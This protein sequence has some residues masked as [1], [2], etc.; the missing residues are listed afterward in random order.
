M[1]CKLQEDS[2]DH[3]GVEDGGQGALLGED[4]EGLHEGGREGGRKG[5][6]EGGGREEGR[7]GLWLYNCRIH[8]VMCIRGSQ[9]LGPQRELTNINT[10]Y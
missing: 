10:H 4:L 9:S 6:R 1:D 2:E 3:V 5:G 8:T 7:G